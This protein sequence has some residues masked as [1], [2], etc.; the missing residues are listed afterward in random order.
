MVGT[1]GLYLSLYV[2]CMYVCVCTDNPYLISTL[3]FQ[4][5]MTIHCIV[6]STG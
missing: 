2:I 6:W 5:K 4:Q 3:T 1:M